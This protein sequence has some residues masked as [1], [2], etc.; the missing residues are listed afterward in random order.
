MFMCITN[1]GTR[2]V[3]MLQ[4]PCNLNHALPFAMPVC[5]VLYCHTNAFIFKCVGSLCF[6]LKMSTAP[7]PHS[8]RCG[9]GKFC[10]VPAA[11]VTFESVKP[12]TRRVDVHVVMIFAKRR[13]VSEVTD[14]GAHLIGEVYRDRK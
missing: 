12:C 13:D 1:L 10:R 5:S 9:F 14:S 3:N 2:A 7:R 11:R 6:G 4:A 8:A